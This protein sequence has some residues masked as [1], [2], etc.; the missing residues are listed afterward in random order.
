MWRY[1]T[2]PVHKHLEY[3]RGISISTE[4]VPYFNAVAMNKQDIFE[5]WKRLSYR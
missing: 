5:S 2:F 3:C 4:E 1:K